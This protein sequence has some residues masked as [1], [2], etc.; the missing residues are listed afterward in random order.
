[1]HNNN[2]KEQLINCIIDSYWLQDVY[3]KQTIWMIFE[4]IPP[5]I[6]SDVSFTHIFSNFLHNS[7]SH[8]VIITNII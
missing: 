2:S 3:I 8:S 5:T 1:M 7:V 4:Q 6:A